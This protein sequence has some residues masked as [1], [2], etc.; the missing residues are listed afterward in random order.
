M[1]GAQEKRQQGEANKPK[2]VCPAWPIVPLRVLLGA[3]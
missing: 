2:E 3:M 1:A